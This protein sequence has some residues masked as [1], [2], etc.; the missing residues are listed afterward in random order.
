MRNQ[1]MTARPAARNEKANEK[2]AQKTT[3][4]ASKPHAI[5]QTVERKSTANAGE[6]PKKPGSL[7]TPSSTFV[8]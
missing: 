3:A 1:A 4:V 6:L 2:R 5:L 7:P 8:F